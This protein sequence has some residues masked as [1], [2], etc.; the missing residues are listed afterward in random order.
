MNERKEETLEEM[1]SRWRYQARE[2]AE[3]F[4]EEAKMSKSNPPGFDPDD[5]RIYTFYVGKKRGH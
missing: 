4:A 2:W 5:K 1:K 3:G